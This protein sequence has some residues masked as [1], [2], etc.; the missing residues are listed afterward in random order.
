VLFLALAPAVQAGTVH[1]ANNGLDS[2][3]CGTKADPCRS[4]TQGIKNA[5]LGDHVT[6]GPGAYRAESGAPGR[7]SP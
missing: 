4:I 5:G 1:V 7:A 3:S 2:G 6:V